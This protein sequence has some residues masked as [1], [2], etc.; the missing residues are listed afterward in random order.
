[1]K[2][3]IRRE[4]LNITQEERDWWSELFEIR[5]YFYKKFQNVEIEAQS[6]EISAS[7]E[8]TEVEE[9][10]K[11]VKAATKKRKMDNEEGDDNK[12]SKKKQKLNKEKSEQDK[13]L[14]KEE[15]KRE[16]ANKKESKKKKKQ[17]ERED[18]KANEQNST[19]SS[20]VTITVSP[21]NF[22]IY[23]LFNVIVSCTENEFAS[24]ME[25]RNPKAAIWRHQRARGLLLVRN[26]LF[27]AVVR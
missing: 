13:K 17:I 18:R 15:K 11:K 25:I 8:A 10:P 6:D 24:W 21:I 23:L 14:E 19:A 27:N 4:D 22:I 5:D 16:K 2:W 9:L 3:N 26:I 20:S 12:K 7:E 1:M